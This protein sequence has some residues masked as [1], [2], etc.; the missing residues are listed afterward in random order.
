MVAPPAANKTAPS[1][2][3]RRLH[4]EIASMCT[5]PPWPHAAKRGGRRLLGVV[6]LSVA[7]G[8]SGVRPNREAGSADVEPGVDARRA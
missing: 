2:A 8:P 5:L 6:W 1:S 3:D 7:P 4:I